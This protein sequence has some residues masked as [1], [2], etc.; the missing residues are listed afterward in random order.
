MDMR[1]VKLLLFQVQMLIIEEIKY[2]Q[3]LNEIK[4]SKCN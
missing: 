4:N 1:I 2:R 3:M